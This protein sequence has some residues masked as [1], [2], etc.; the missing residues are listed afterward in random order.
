[1]NIG[2]EIMIRGKIVNLDTNPHGE[3][4]KVEIKG[5]QMEEK[6]TGWY[7]GKKQTKVG[8][9]IHRLDQPEVIVKK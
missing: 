8:F 9:W 4:I 7:K 1:M 5:F 3:A 2:D 6:D